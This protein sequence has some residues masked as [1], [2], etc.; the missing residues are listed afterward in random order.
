MRCFLSAHKLTAAFDVCVV[1]Q[2]ELVRKLQLRNR[3]HGAHKASD[4]KTV[5]QAH[6]LLK[7]YLMN[8]DL[9][10]SFASDTVRTKRH[11]ISGRLCSK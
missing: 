7:N 4:N 11:R 10:Y 2:S 1:T 3:I 9:I 5:P 6:Y 8:R